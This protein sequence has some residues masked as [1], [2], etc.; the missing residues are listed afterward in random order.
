MGVLTFFILA[1]YAAQIIQIYFFS[2]PSAGSTVEML[3]KVKKDPARANCHPA[4]HI[5]Y[6]RLLAK[7][8]YRRSVPH[9]RRIFFGAA[10]R[11]NAVR[12]YL[13]FIEFDLSGENGRSLLAARIW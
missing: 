10:F 2:V 13:L 12:L 7:S 4:A 8:D 9:L 11:N 6:L 3:F 1:T 5:R